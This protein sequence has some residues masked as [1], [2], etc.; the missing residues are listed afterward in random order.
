VDERV[1]I[2]VWI[3]WTQLELGGAAVAPPGENLT[4]FFNR[5]LV[6]TEGMVIF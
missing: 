6:F 1:L 4:G 3:G 5:L 2:C